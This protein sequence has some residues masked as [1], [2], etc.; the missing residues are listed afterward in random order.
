MIKSIKKLGV[1]LF[2]ISVSI[3]SLAQSRLSNDTSENYE[4]EYYEEDGGLTFKVRFAGILSDGKQ[5]DLP[6]PTVN[7]PISVGKFV[8]NGYG[9]DASTTI[10]FNNYFGAELSIG[11][12]VLRTKNSSIGNV[13]NNYGANADLGKRKD[14]FMIP[15]T[16]TG[17]FHIAPFG[18]IRPYIGVGYHGSYLFSQ[19]KG[20]KIK[21]GHGAVGQVG[22]DFYAK[23]DTLINFDVR[24]FLLS[25][26][27]TYKSNIVGSNNVTSKVKLNPL[28]ISIGIG[29]NF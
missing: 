24:Q 16:V 6:P 20:F 4:T 21:N 15:A 17:Q 14:T 7:T 13:A 18:G 5:K 29:F 22:I 26:K 28:V 19:N 2:I 3:N 27:V 11:L 1:C 25:P 9:G 12:N 10:F 8:E 23:D